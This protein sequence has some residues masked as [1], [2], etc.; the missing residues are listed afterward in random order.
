MTYSIETTVKYISSLFYLEFQTGSEIVAVV[1]DSI[2]DTLKVRDYI[3]NWGMARGFFYFEGCV[4]RN[5]KEKDLHC[6]PQFICSKDETKSAVLN[7]INYYDVVEF[8]FFNHGKEDMFALSSFKR[9]WGYG[10]IHTPSTTHWRT[11]FLSKYDF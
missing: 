6:N 10:A 4:Y 2:F 5:K 1:I 11:K 8:R 7:M 3:E 9:P